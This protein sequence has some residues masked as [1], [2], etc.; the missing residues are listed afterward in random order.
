MIDEVGG[1]LAHVAAVAGRADAAALAGEGH[2]KSRA[3]RH[4]DRAGEAEAEDAALEI[5]AK[6]LLDI[7]RH[8]PLRG[9][10]PFE[11]ALDVLRDD[12]VERGLLGAA[13]L[14]TA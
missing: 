5:A 12:L 2:D 10:P 6:V 13:T 8:G 7:A 11:P 14:V 4:A 1:R 9:F 3:A